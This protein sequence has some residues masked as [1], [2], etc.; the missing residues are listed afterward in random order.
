MAVAIIKRVARFLLYTFADKNIRKPVLAIASK[1]ST[2]N[3]KIL[4]PMQALWKAC[5]VLMTIS[6]SFRT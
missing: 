2:V 6:N 1:G 4:K 5:C 3:L